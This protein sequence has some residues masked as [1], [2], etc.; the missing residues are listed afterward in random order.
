MLDCYCV[1]HSE[2]SSRADCKHCEGFNSISIQIDVF[3]NNSMRTIRV[4]HRPTGIS[5]SRDSEKT[6]FANKNKALKELIE[7]VK[8]E[9]NRTRS[10]WLW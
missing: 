8:N 1:C 9:R 2:L 7:K 6:F 3:S 10:I 4:T 5:V